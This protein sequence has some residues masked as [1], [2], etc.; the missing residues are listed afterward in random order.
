MERR[1]DDLVARVDVWHR[2]ERSE[3]RVSFVPHELGICGILLLAARIVS[4]IRWLLHFAGTVLFLLVI[5]MLWSAMDSTGSFLASFEQGGLLRLVAFG[6]GATE[7]VLMISGFI[8][9]LLIPK[10]R[11]RL[12]PW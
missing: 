9:L 12:E 4:L 7:I 6:F 10:R 11:H 1:R 2:S 3:D 5:T 8:L